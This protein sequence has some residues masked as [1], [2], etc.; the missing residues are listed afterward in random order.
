M[1]NAFSS[2]VG[3]QYKYND[4]L[5]VAKLARPGEQFIESS[6]HYFHSEPWN[7]E[8]SNGLGRSTRSSSLLRREIYGAMSIEE[9]TC[10]SLHPPFDHSMDC[11]FG[12]GSQHLP[13]SLMSNASGTSLEISSLSE[14]LRP[15][16][17]YLPWNAFHIDF[18]SDLISKANAGG[19]QM[20]YIIFDALQDFTAGRFA[21]DD[22]QDYFLSPMDLHPTILLYDDPSEMQKRGRSLLSFDYHSEVYRIY[23]LSF[24][25]TNE[26]CPFLN[27]SRH[28]S[29]V[30]CFR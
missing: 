25:K 22:M 21:S 24:A 7:E 19:Q 20:D 1:L 27:S 8:I 23:I 30:W 9:V 4:L 15:C 29:P 11:G 12:L 3:L 13:K 17:I 28:S 14:Q 18:F 5:K 6:L 2:E 16:D 10:E 26:F